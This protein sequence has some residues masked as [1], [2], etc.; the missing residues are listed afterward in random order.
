MNITK[1]SNKN[2]CMGY[3]DTH[4]QLQRFIYNRS[5]EAF[6]QGDATRDA[7]DSME[8][9]ERYRNSMREKFIELLGGLPDSD[10]PLNPRVT[11]TEQCDGF[12]I[13]KVIFESR[14]K[15]YVTANLYIPDSVKEPTGAV[16]FLCGHSSDG[17]HYGPYQSVCLHLVGAGL[18]V[19]A[20]DP[21]GQGE[22]HSY[23]ERELGRAAIEPAVFDHDYAGVKCLPVGDSPAR[24][25]VHDA[26]RALDYMCTRPEIDPSRIGV[27]GSSG[28]GTQ[29]CMLMI[30]DSRVAAAAP[31]NFLMNRESYMYAG[32]PQDS[33]QL[34]PGYTACGFDHEDFLICMAPKPVLVNAVKYDF[35]PIEGTLRTVERARRFWTMYGK[36]N[37]ILMHEDESIHAYTPKLAS[38]TAGF[39][40]LH[41]LG[42][43]YSNLQCRATP[44]QPEK[45]KCTSTGQVKGAFE[46]SRFVHDENMGRLTEISV[47]HTR[48]TEDERRKNAEEWLK[49]RVFNNRRPCELNPRRFHEGQ[50]WELTVDRY[51]WWSQEGL[52]SHALCFRHIKYMGGKL[53]VTIAVWDGGTSALGDHACWLRDECMAGRAVLVLD[54]AG[55]GSL[56]PHP[57]N[58][59]EIHD[60]YGTLRKFADDLI[61][62]DDS[63]PALRTYEVIR[64]LDA[65][66]R[67]DHFSE[68]DIMVHGSGR[69]GMY[70]LLAGFADRRIK[71]VRLEN[72]TDSLE[73]LVCAKYYD[74][75][76]IKDIILPGMLKYFDLPDLRCWMGEK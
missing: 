68:D 15:S 7:I 5:V 61:W 16:L 67:M 55:T 41:L 76:G 28:G 6:R 24:Y 33:E 54:V 36:E 4:S 26:M 2:A 9:L 63:M 48:N 47:M 62:L 11:G 45:L 66:E 10:T 12:K 30:C 73:K 13:E 17:K 64:T 51:M 3:Y 18:V 46:D 34:W 40:S 25:F 32:G 44:L 59:R 27:T 57:V 1:L 69:Y 14:P 50:L 35:F 58:D 60:S 49:G 29:T 39:F 31:T 19:F 8:E 72:T 56:E 22:R 43:E 52:Y 75:S 38:G 70:G 37:N 65:I 71:K 23:Y 42:R 74:D 21:V 20:V 53:P